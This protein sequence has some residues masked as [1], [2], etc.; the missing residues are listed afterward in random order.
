MIDLDV[1][2]AVQNS[3][4]VLKQAVEIRKEE[5]RDPASAQPYRPLYLTPNSCEVFILSLWNTDYLKLSYHG[6]CHE[7]RV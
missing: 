4:D 7:I 2:V 6:T 1:P 5:I 3:M